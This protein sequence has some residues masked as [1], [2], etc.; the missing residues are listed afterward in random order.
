MLA[1][2]VE[3]FG[4]E[5]REFRTARS[6]PVLIPLTIFVLMLLTERLETEQV[7]IRRA[8]PVQSAPARC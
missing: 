4:K 7:S 1:Q 2:L 8:V 5:N 6:F 3:F